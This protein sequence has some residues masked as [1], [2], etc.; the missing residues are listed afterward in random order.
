MPAHHHAPPR[1]PL[2]ARGVHCTVQELTLLRAVASSIDLAS[3]RSASRAT[4]SGA[5]S[6]QRG[7]G[8]E[9]EEVRAYS[10]GDDVRSI[11]WRVSARTGR[12]HTRLFRAE[13]ERPVY[14][15]LDQR[16]PM[17]FGTRGSMKSVQ[18]AYAGALLAWAALTGGDR[19]G[20]IVLA[21]SG[22]QETRPRRS[23]RT[24]LELL[25]MI[26]ESNALLGPANASTGAQESTLGDA[27]AS[28]RR[29]SR[30]GS[31]LLLLSDFH[32]WDEAC[33]VQLRLLSRHCE[34]HGLEV[35]DPMERS[36]PPAG[37]AMFSD[38]RLQLLTDTSSASLRSAYAQA[39][40]LRL[41]QLEDAF[42]MARARF[43][44]LPTGVDAA[45]I[46]GRCYARR[47][48]A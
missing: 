18:A 39:S 1:A 40:A 17:F 13:R 20:G 27:L 2:L 15:L 14:I 43:T 44:S 21:Q 42:R 5:P 35:H 12:A 25:R 16:H 9:F 33:S 4:G 24:V 3:P 6:R 47:R 22:Q 34:V 30:P 7:R 41:A 36:L 28:L 37:M 19:V 8:L 23:R 31:L 46:L 11:D 10:P 38:G 45:E 48:G 29:L 32:D 26:C